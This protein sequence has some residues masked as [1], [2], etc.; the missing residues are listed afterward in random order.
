MLSLCFPG[1]S[2]VSTSKHP[3]PPSHLQVFSLCKADRPAFLCEKFGRK[4]RKGVF[5]LPRQREGPS[6]KEG[7]RTRSR[8]KANLLET[9]ET[10]LA[11]IASSSSRPPQCLTIK[12]FLPL[13]VAFSHWPCCFPLVLTQVREQVLFSCHSE[14]N[15]QAKKVFLGVYKALQ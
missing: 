12:D 6:F 9:H 13:V 3:M 10:H 5:Y 8:P 4:S 15:K 1:R 11:S 7:D 2:A 14:D